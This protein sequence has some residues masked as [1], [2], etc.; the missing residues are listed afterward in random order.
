M[1]ECTPKY[2]IKLFNSEVD[3]EAFFD[4]EGSPIIEG[5]WDADILLNYINI[6]M[7]ELVSRT[8]C[9]GTNTSAYPV[10]KRISDI[11]VDLYDQPVLHAS[12]NGTDLRVVTSHDFPYIAPDLGLIIGSPQWRDKMG[13]PQFLIV[14]ESGGVRVWPIPT[15]DLEVEMTVVSA[16]TGPVDSVDSLIELP[17]KWVPGLLLKVRELAFSKIRSHH[18]FHFLANLN[19]ELWEEFVDD[20]A[21]EV[22][23]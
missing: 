14:S 10:R 17:A 6:A 23:G 2:L 5:E 16:L 21:K 3:D 20:V 15:D 1:I 8:R 11:D 4:E 22:A 9:L 18:T 19:A 7:Y 12:I 13:F